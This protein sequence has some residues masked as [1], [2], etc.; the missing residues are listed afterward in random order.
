MLY[1]CLEDVS[2]CCACLLGLGDEGS[3]YYHAPPIKPQEM[4]CTGVGA[5]FDTDTN[6]FQSDLGYCYACVHFTVRGSLL[7]TALSAFNS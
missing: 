1:S 7:L 2:S 6:M 5:S 3:D 4:Y